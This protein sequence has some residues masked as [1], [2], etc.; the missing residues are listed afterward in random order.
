MLF[1]TLSIHRKFQVIYRFQPII[2]SLSKSPVNS[3]MYLYATPPW[4][5]SP[6]VGSIKARLN[7]YSSSLGGQ[8]ILAYAIASSALHTM[9]PC[10]YVTYFQSMCFYVKR[11]TASVC[12]RTLDALMNENMSAK[13]CR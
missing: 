13:G 4:C 7:N 1:R 3:N 10:C 8:R 2:R 11:T 6:G 5:R 12:E 9:E